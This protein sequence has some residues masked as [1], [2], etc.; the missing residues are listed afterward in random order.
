VLATLQ[1]P[2]V[3]RVLQDVG[4]IHALVNVVDDDNT[5][6]GER[7][8]FGVGIAYDEPSCGRANQCRNCSDDAVGNFVPDHSNTFNAVSAVQRHA[9]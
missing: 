7:H 6:L 5:L 9:C 4:G 1:S 8:M 3:L 2:S